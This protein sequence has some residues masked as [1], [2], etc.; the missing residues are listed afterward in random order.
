MLLFQSVSCHVCALDLFPLSTLANVPPSLVP[1][2]RGSVLSS[3]SFVV[4]KYGA[5]DFGA[6]LEPVYLSHFW[7]EVEVLFF[8]ASSNSFA[9][10]IIASAGVTMGAVV[11]LCLNNT[12]SD[13]CTDLVFGCHPLKYL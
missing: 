5:K 4:V 3:S 8:I 10:C 2:L 1:T 13:P 12:V 6:F 11:Y 7:L 9:A